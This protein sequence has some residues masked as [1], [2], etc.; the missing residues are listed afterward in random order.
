MNKDNK[1]T[2]F[3]HNEIERFFRL[4]E[5]VLVVSALYFLSGQSGHILLKVIYYASSFF[6]YI[7]ILN[8]SSALIDPYSEIRFIKKYRLVLKVIVFLISAF[9]TAGL[10]ISINTLIEEHLLINFR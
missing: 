4:L 8:I 10:Q 3:S 1:Y 5:Y 9:L 7:E 6:L 2:A